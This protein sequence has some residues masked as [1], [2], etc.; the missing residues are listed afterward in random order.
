MS[1][2]IDD[3]NTYHDLTRS[4]VI[5]LQLMLC[6]QKIEKDRYVDTLSRQNSDINLLEGNDQLREQAKVTLT[7]QRLKLNATARAIKATEQ[8]MTI[9]AGTL[10]QIARQGLV[11]RYGQKIEDCSTQGRMVSGAHL[12]E[13]IWLGRNQSMHFDDSRPGSWTQLFK[14]LDQHHPGQ[15]T[16]EPVSRSMEI[17]DLLGWISFGQYEAD[18]ENLGIF[19]RSSNG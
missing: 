17:I 8:T 3:A 13:I 11:T 14:G 1:T 9:V 10:L 15:F 16:S 18:M 19:T 6:E 12:R 2:K 4:V 5:A 7:R